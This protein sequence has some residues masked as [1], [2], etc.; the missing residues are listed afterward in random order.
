MSTKKL[1]ILNSIITTDT[2]LSQSG[3]A[4]DSK[5]V[6]DALAEKLAN[7]ALDSA[8]N[9]A[10]T[11]AKESGEFDG[12]QGDDGVGILNVTQTTTST[13]DDGNNV[14]AVTLTNGTSYTFTVQNGSKGSTGPK[15]E[16]GDAGYSP[17]RGTDYWT[18]T[19]K[20]EIKSYVDE[21]ILGGAW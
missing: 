13:S 5:A 8:I 9:N 4:A 20:A 1:Q 3:I 2:T 21:A 16:T 6:G 7:T 19:D 10:L 11:V 14:I 15:G 12:A 17:V 18:D